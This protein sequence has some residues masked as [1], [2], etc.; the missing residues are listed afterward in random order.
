MAPSGGQAGGQ[1][2]ERQVRAPSNADGGGSLP[3]TRLGSDHLGWAT[4]PAFA[5]W[6]RREACVH[7]FD[8]IST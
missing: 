5:C 4:I 3:S 6:T 7:K 2:R 8:F 1:T